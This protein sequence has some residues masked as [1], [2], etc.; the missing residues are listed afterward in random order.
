MPRGVR[1]LVGDD[2]HEVAQ[3]AELAFA[4]ERVNE[5][6]FGTFALDGE[7]D[8]TGDKCQDLLFVFA[9]RGFVSW[10]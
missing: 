7:R 2:G 9:V 3:L 6:A 5:F 10:W 4:F 8:L 1:K